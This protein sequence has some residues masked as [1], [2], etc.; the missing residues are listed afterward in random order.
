VTA[1]AARWP[2]RVMRRSRDEQQ[3]DGVKAMSG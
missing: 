1:Q 3:A 2:D